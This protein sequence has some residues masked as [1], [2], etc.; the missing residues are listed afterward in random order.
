M[1]EVKKARRPNLKDG[2]LFCVTLAEGH[3]YAFGYVALASSKSGKLVDVFDHVSA[4]QT[5]PED[6]EDQ[7]LILH[8][9]LTGSGIFVQ[10]RNNPTPWRL[11]GRRVSRMRPVGQALLQ[12]GG[13]VFDLRTD[14]LIEEPAGVDWRTLPRHSLPLDDAHTWKI[15]AR[16]LRRDYRFKE[17]DSGWELTP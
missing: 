8:N 12:I 3:G 17:D 13:K 14:G 1:V 6:I 9:L 7:P 15:T 10:T 4:T 16:L 11:L 5:P 2:D